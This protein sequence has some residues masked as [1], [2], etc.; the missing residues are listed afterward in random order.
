MNKP[1]KAFCILPWVH[2][3]VRQNAE[4]YPCCRISH[5]FSYGSIKEKTLDQV[6]NSEAAKKVRREMLAGIPQSFCTDCVKLEDFGSQSYRDVVNHEFKNEFSRITETDET[7]FLKNNT[8]PYLDLRF[9]NVCNLKCRTCNSENSTTWIDDEKKLNPA[10]SSTLAS[11]HILKLKNINPEIINQLYE[12]LPAV[13]SIYFAGGEPLLD[14]NHYL[15]LEKLIELGRTDVILSY[16]TNLSVLQFKKW[17]AIKLWQQFEHVQVS[18]SIDAIGP[19]LE[20]IR[21]GADWNMIQK[22]LKLIKLF[23]PNSLIVIY[24]TISV[25]N[26]FNITTLIDYFLKHN[27]IQITRQIKF[28]ILNEPEHLNVSLLDENKI[29]RLEEHY[30]AFLQTIKADCSAEVFEYLTSELEVIVK[31]A[32]SKNLQ[33]FRPK[34]ATETLNLDTI[35]NENTS[36]ILPELAFILDPSETDSF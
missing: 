21:K 7:G 8:I 25:L 12:K 36:V 18:A 35:R 22:N 29:N 16:N 3:Q 32:R 23:I 28:N 1:N 20:L 26:C 34:F 17:N 19:A 2:V 14:E 11:S 10:F 15:L 33:S 27:Y 31:F 5:G 13:S 4:L 9:S 24:P 30:R 6:W